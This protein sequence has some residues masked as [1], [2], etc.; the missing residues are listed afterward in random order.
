MGTQGVDELTPAEVTV[1]TDVAEAQPPGVGGASVRTQSS[2]SSS[3][4]LSL[5][6]PLREPPPLTVDEAMLPARTG[7]GLSRDKRRIFV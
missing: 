4:T 7:I 1:V 5:M 6:S 3:S 2:A